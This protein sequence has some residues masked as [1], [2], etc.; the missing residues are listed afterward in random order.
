MQRLAHQLVTLETQV[1]FLLRPME[2]DLVEITFYFV[3]GKNITFSISE[4]YYKEIRDALKSRWNDVNVTI[5]NYGINCS[6]V[7]HYCVKNE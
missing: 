3:S 5:D 2:K 4:S 1:R 6:L 7:T